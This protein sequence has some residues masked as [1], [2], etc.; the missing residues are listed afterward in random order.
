MSAWNKN[1][2]S[3]A[4]Y[5]ASTAALPQDWRVNLVFETMEHFSED[6]KRVT[7]TCVFSGF[8]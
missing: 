5:Q 3:E 1:D 2:K 8:P 6:P 7:G 4:R